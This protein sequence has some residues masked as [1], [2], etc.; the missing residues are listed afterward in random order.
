MKLW[1]LSHSKYQQSIA[2]TLLH[3]AILVTENVGITVHAK[4]VGHVVNFRSSFHGLM[5]HEQ[6]SFF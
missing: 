5:G 4:T 2:T 6:G 3:R 1:E